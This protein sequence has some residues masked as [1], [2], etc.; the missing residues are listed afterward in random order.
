MIVEILEQENG[1]PIQSVSRQLGVSHMTVRPDLEQLVADGQ[2]KLIHG[3]VILV[4]G[5][6][7]HRE[8]NLYSPN[9]AETIR[10]EEMQR[11]GIRAA[12]LVE[13]DDT[14]IIDSGST[15]EFPAYNIPEDLALTILCYALS[16]ISAIVRLKG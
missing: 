14:L 3:G 5:N 2:G 6:D 4:P 13:A 1:L 15:T 9:A 7:L 12:M 10:V 16:T 8:Q 11:I